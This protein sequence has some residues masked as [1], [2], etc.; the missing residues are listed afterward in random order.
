[1]EETL[2]QKQIF[3]R[4]N[5]LDKGYNADDFMNLLCSK[6]GESGLDLNNWRMDELSSIVSEF[7]S[8]QNQN[9]DLKDL[10]HDFGAAIGYSIITDEIKTIDDAINE[11]TLDMKNN[12]QESR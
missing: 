2:K 3:L 11:A 1:M 6:K 7:I 9:K 10:S 12:K 4:E 8:M 5:I